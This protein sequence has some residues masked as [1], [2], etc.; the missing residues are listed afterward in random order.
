MAKIIL[1]QA[2][3]NY[4]YMQGT[5]TVANN[6][7]TNVVDTLVSDV[8]IVIQKTVCATYFKPGDK[9]T[10]SIS[11]ANVGDAPSVNTVV[12]DNLV[13]QDYIDGSTSVTLNGQNYTGYT[14]GNIII[15]QRM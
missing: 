14:V 15:L 6:V 4:N 1:N 5:T 12:Y 3:I 8:K 13:S 2:S 7:Q 10:Y 11:V 9:L